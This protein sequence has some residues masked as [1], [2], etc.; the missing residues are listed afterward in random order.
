[1]AASRVAVKG[2]MFKWRSVISGVSQ[3]SML[4]LVLFNIF[5]TDIV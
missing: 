3:G 1:M 5:I 4:G 2:S